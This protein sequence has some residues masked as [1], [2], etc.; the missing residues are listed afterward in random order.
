L[1]LAYCR[2]NEL[3]ASISHDLCLIHSEKSLAHLKTLKCSTSSYVDVEFGLNGGVLA[4]SFKDGSVLLWDPQ[5]WSHR[6]TA[7]VA[8]SPKVTVGPNFTLAVYDQRRLWMCDS[9]Q[10]NPV[11]Q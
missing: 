6:C 4:S 5:E 7:V 3:I 11:Y 10:P 1:K 8:S 9:S 2:Q